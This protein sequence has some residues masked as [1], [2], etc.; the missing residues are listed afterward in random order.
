MAIAVDM[1][2]MN[3]PAPPTIPSRGEVQR[4]FSQVR[5][6]SGFTDP[7][8]FSSIVGEYLATLDQPARQKVLDEAEQTRAFVRTLSPVKL[9]D[10]VGRPLPSDPYIDAMVK[11]AR[12]SQAFGQRPFQFAMVKPD[13]LIALQTTVKP[14]ADTVPSDPA[15]LLRFALPDKYEVP[16]EMTFTPPQGPIYITSRH[17]NMQGIAM[18]MEQ[19]RLVIRPP[20]HLN[21]IQVAHF[22]GRFY[23]RNGYHRV[24][25][26]I[27][28]G[29][30]EIPAIV[31]Q[32]LQVQEVD[33]GGAA[34]YNVG[35]TMRLQRPPLM[36]DFLNAATMT[37]SRRE[38]LYGVMVDLMIKPLNV[39]I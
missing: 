32:P 18:D 28:A 8:H 13:R 15:D 10:A 19:G 38:H 14:R 6:L 22:Q 37:T 29:V 35:Y 23:L 1:V 27:S 5:V 39:G 12:F 3:P 2:T 25:D 21:L 36:Q 34:N 9:D 7:G 11:D 24:F 4:T 26:A 30:A 17:P 33:I 20:M 16:A 31:T